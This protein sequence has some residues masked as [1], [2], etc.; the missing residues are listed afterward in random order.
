M[1]AG[2]SACLN[3]T[4]S[5]HPGNRNKYK[6]DFLVFKRR[7]VTFALPKIKVN[8]AYYS[9]IS[10]KRKRDNQGKEQIKGS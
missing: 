4:T 8:N 3:D 9:T 5:R 10:K 7:A 6:N 1:I 2:R